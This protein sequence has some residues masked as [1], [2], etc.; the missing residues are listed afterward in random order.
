MSNIRGQSKGCKFCF[1]VT[2]LLCSILA[3][4]ISLPKFFVI[5]SDIT[6]SISLPANIVPSLFD[7]Q[8]R[9]LSNVI[10]KNEA[11]REIT[12]CSVSQKATIDTM[13]PDNDALRWETKCPDKTWIDSY[14]VLDRPSNYG[15]RQPNFPPLAIF[16]G[17]N[18]GFDA[19][20]AL[21]MISWNET[22]NKGQWKQIM[23][24]DVGTCNQGKS[25]QFSIPTA[26]SSSISS[27]RLDNAMVFCIEAM[28]STYESLARSARALHWQE[29]F[30]IIHAAVSDHNKESILFPND[31]V[32]RSNLGI[33]DCQSPP[34]G[35]NMSSTIPSLRKNNKKMEGC[36]NVTQYTLDSL[37]KQEFERLGWT[38]ESTLYSPAFS[39]S[40][41][42]DFLSVDVEGF[43]WP[44]L[45]GSKVILT[46]VKYLEFEYHSVGK[47][48]EYDITV[49]IDTLYDE[50]GFVCYWAGLEGKLWRITKCWID[51]HRNEGDKWKRWSNVACVQP[52]LAPILAERMEQQFLMTLKNFETGQLLESDENQDQDSV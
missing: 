32:G 31:R 20:D 33:H 11:A 12:A 3:L 52:K 43:D 23:D 5:E 42:I 26:S 29:S 14:F 38:A 19:L 48:Q 41:V 22:Y 8:Q 1:V 4:S 46:H 37:M 40:F 36:A 50:H 13:I 17:C 25:P 27:H 16:A 18:R 35:Q 51:E 45:L 30:K 24:I 34:S 44:V 49:A 9:S 28:P 21:R 39:S 6:Y 15:L 10:S 7:V 2:P 47:W